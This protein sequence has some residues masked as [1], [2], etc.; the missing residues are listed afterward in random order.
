[1]SCTPHPSSITIILWH[2]I[3]NSEVLKLESPLEFLKIFIWQAAVLL[4]IC[5][6]KNKLLSDIDPYK[7]NMNYVPMSDIFSSTSQKHIWWKTTKHWQKMLSLKS[8]PQSIF[9]S[10]FQALHMFS[11]YPNASPL[12]QLLILTPNSAGRPSS[13]PVTNS[14][15]AWP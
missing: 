15:T 14:H 12:S 4:A 11:F 2:P 7:Q 1:M 8:V 3:A 10:I 13:Y 6:H 5:A 9:W